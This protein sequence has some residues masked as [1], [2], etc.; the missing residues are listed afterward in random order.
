MR[1]K[2]IVLAAGEFP[3]KNTQPRRILDSAKRVVCCDSAAD[4]YLK[5]TGLF[6]AAVVGDCDSLKGEFNN[7]VRISEQQT[8][9]LEKAVKY[10]RER[11]WSD[12]VVLGAVGKR[13]DHSIGNV[14]RALALGVEIVTKHGR[15]VPVCG[16]RR[17]KVRKGA[18]ISVFPSSPSTEMKSKGLQWPLEGVKFSNLYVATLN[19]ATHSSIQI[20][21][22]EPV[23]LF[24]EY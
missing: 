23:M 2:T 8:N 7:V 9:D 24:M 3:A 5:K 21:S 1:G 11:G 4:C 6:P 10:C 15:F 22:T 18:A 13:E 19:R 16:V 20:E 14:F 17:F 12:I